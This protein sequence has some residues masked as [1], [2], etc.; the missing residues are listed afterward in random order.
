MACAEQASLLLSLRRG[1]GKP[2]WKL[3]GSR[4]LVIDGCW[5]VYAADA[6][7][8]LPLVVSHE[9]VVLVADVET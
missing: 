4:F 7:G 1:V 2:L 3:G 5:L 6:A 8:M 9:S